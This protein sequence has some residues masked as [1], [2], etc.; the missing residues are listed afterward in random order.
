MQ[1][2]FSVAVERSPEPGI[3]QADL[4]MVLGHGKGDDKSEDYS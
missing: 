1:T 3:S 4:M 2:G